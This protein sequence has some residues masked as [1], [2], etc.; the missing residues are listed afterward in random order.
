MRNAAAPDPSVTT[1]SDLDITGL[2]TAWAAEVSEVLAA[3]VPWLVLHAWCDRDGAI[4]CVELSHFA[5]GN[6]RVVSVSRRA[7]PSPETRKEELL[8]LLH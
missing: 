3:G 6:R 2:T 5:T 4:C 7:Y 1:M 8:R